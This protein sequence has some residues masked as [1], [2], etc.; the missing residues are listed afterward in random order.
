MGDVCLEHEL[1][2]LPEP[3]PSLEDTLAAALALDRAGA[4]G[5]PST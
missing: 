3:P 5:P 4:T 2:P 1:E